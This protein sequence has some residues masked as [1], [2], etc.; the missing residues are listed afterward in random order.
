MQ[1]SKNH[2]FG[3]I[4]LFI[5]IVAAYLVTTEPWKK[6][7]RKVQTALV[8]ET[9]SMV[10]PIAW[11]NLST[12][13][14]LASSTDTILSYNG[15]DLSYNEQYKQVSWVAYV[16]TRHEIKSGTFEQSDNFRS[17][18]NIASGSA[19]LAD[20][21]GSGLDRGIWK[22]LESEA[23]NW[24]LEKDSI[25]VITGPVLAPIDS[26]FGEH[27]EE[28]PQHYYKVIVDLSPPTIH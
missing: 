3:L 10:I 8:P 28:I 19:A 21:R 5:L 15:F 27:Q 14:P 23:R 4:T 2:R 16:L 13:H 25:Y 7:P 6:N 9:S 11:D 22:K 20:Y 17:D 24:A 18:P 26:F 1:I 12:G